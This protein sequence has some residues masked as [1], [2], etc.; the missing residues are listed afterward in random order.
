M[1]F[2]SPAI[3]LLS[4]YFDQSC[5]LYSSFFGGIMFGA[6]F[7]LTNWWLKKA[8]CFRF[9]SHAPLEVLWTSLPIFFLFVTVLHSLAIL[10][11]LEV[12]KPFSSSFGQVTGNQWYWSYI[13][14]TFSS[15]ALDSRLVPSNL[16]YPGSPRLILVDQPL[17][18]PQFSN[19]SLQIHSNDVIH[20]FSLPAL[21][22]KVDAVPGRNSNLS[23]SGL[24]PG[25]Y[26]GFCSELCG[27]GHAFMPINLCIF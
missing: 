6:L 11:A 26:I 13:N 4:S 2:S 27:S 16:L 22:I 18:L 24:V 15:G 21:G 8:S 10:Y 12:D 9:S 19:V 25:F 1:T 14:P 7:V 17:F 20:S 5:V 23:L 3:E